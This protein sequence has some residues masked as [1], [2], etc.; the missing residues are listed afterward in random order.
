MDAGLELVLAEALRLV[1]EGR[2]AMAV[3]HW[4]RLTAARP[5]R[6]DF[7]EQLMIALSQ[8]G[9]ND[10]ACAHY[11]RIPKT[12]LLPSI[13]GFDEIYVQALLATGSPPAPLKRRPRMN[14]LLR[15]LQPTDT[16]DGAIAECGCFRGLSAFMLC[17]AIKARSAIFDGNGFHVFDSFQG[18]SDPMPEDDIADDTPN[19]SVMRMMTRAG[20]FAATLEQVRGSLGAFPG[21]QFHPGWIPASFKGQAERRYRFVHVD[22]DLYDPTRDA[23][24][25]FYPRLAPGGRIVSDDYSW[26]GARQALEEFARANA[27]ELRTNDIGQALIVKRAA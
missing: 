7:L 24:E 14:E 21:I 17:S 26:P 11:A 6:I 25:Y 2:A 23:L 13:E 1:N 10:E 3:A 9:R 22:V 20:A 5:D 12:P 19:A 18:L 16:I 4:Q 8:A 15:A 27:V